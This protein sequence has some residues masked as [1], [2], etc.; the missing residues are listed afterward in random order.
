MLM[1]FARIGKMLALTT[2]VNF[3]FFYGFAANAHF[4]FGSLNL[5]LA[6]LVTN[7]SALSMCSKY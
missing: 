5:P 3:S 6:N 1:R 4:Y 7:I 2:F